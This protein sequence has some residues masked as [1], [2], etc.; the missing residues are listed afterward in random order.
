MC[1]SLWC[2]SIQFTV[3]TLIFFNLTT[4]TQLTTLIPALQMR[5]LRCWLTK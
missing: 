2:V 5:S 4:I 1:H 3:C